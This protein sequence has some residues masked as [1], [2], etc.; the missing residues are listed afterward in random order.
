MKKKGQNL[1]EYALILAMIAVIGALFV[2][3]FDLRAIKNYVFMR[4]ADSTDPTKI[5]VEAMTP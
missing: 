4:P 2:S 1:I 3:K 5:K